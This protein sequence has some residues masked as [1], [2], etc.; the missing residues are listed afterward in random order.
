MNR[1]MQRPGHRL[2]HSYKHRQ[3][4]ADICL[5]YPPGAGGNFI[6]GCLGLEQRCSSSAL[7]EYQY[8]HAHWC[9]LDNIPSHSDRWSQ[10]D[11]YDHHLDH[12]WRLALNMQIP[13]NRLQLVMC[14]NPPVLTVQ[15]FDA[16]FDE[17]VLIIPDAA[18]AWYV[19]LLRMIKHELQNDFVQRPWLA[20]ELANLCWEEDLCEPLDN[21]TWTAVRQII[22]ADADLSLLDNSLA[23]WRFVARAQRQDWTITASSIRSFMDQLLHDAA[24]QFARYTDQHMADCLQLLSPYVDRMTVIDYA[25]LFIRGRIPL[26]SCLSRV[27]RGELASYHQ[28]NLLI[29]RQALATLT[30]SRQR[31]LLALLDQ[32]C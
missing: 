14:H 7:N 32:M 8:Q 16:R 27:D 13:G 24:V 30:A 9:L 6:A 20:R 1:L 5:V 25:D 15:A 29:A 4:R 18:S 12:L 26:H 19:G 21:V 17:M 3:L 23:M 28:R 22:L 2:F 11:I 31:Q 10:I